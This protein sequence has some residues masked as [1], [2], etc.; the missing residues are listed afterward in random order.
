MP[1]KT[2]MLTIAMTI[3]ALIIINKVGPLKPVKD[4]ISA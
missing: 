1:S 4:L 2:Q 3:G